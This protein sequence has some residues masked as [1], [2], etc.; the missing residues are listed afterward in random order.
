MPEMTFRKRLATGAPLYASFV[1]TPHHSAIEIA[2]VAGLDA[3]VV[4]AEHAPFSAAA[5]DTA[6]LAGRASDIA[7]IIRVPDTAPATLL[8][9]L[10]LGCSGILVP[11]VTHPDQASAIVASTQYRTG[12]RGFSNSARA[13]RYGALD[14]PA[15]VM[16]GDV[17][18]AVICQ[19]EDADA[20]DHVGDIAKT[21]GVDCLFVG[22]ADLAVSYRVF[23]QRH[24]QVEAATQA[25]LAAAHQA[26][27]PCGIF[28]PDIE[29]ALRYREQGF[30][31]FV[32]GSDQAAMRSGW[33][34]VVNRLHAAPEGASTHQA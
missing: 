16:C 32:I 3:V 31:F 7:A 24:P 5:L 2:G 30:S 29:S 11:H 18:A 25:T 12:N 10:D 28:V 9:V 22:R 17:Q 27:K 13:G 20:I 4:D 34:S 8:Q 26:G 21:E 1:K 19:I 15:H 6:V 23:D 33:T 14:M